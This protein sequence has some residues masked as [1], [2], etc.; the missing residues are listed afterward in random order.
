MVPHARFPKIAILAAAALC[1]GCT[2]NRYRILMMENLV[3]PDGTFRDRIPEDLDWNHTGVRGEILRAAELRSAESTLPEG[4]TRRLR[5]EPVV[6]AREALVDLTGETFHPWFRTRV[7]ATFS[8]IARK[9]PMRVVRAMAL[10][11][12]V[13]QVGYRRRPLAPP[14]FPPAEKAEAMAFL[15][16]LDATLQADS[17]REAVDQARRI[18]ESGSLGA[19]GI[20]RA[21]AACVLLSDLAREH[22]SGRIRTAARN[23]S[24]R[25]CRRLTAQVL[26][27]ALEDEAALVRAQ[28][29]RGLGALRAHWSSADLV[30][31][32][33]EDVSPIVRRAAAA[34]LGDLQSLQAMDSLIRALSRP[35]ENVSVTLRT[36]DSLRAI[37]GANPG[38]TAAEWRAWRIEQTRAQPEDRKTGR[39]EPGAR[40][41]LVKRGSP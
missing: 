29:A 21:R 36:L 9:A 5:E 16:G 8:F 22:R 40:R 15:E 18:E 28:A 32:L 39:R 10:N 23:A 30:A 38:N 14:P 20:V 2:S 17:R 7:V 3:R 37:T 35:N 19:L 4:P 41:G 12:M 6:A 24:W 25:F 34:A 13:D 11:G 1:L 26:L 27:A 31:R 33:S